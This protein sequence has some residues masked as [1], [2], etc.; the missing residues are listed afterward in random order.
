MWCPPFLVAPPKW[1]WELDNIRSYVR[2][3]I[4]MFCVHGKANSWFVIPG[5][6]WCVSCPSVAATTWP[7]DKQ[8]WQR[9]PRP[10]SVRDSNTW[11]WHRPRTRRMHHW[12]HQ[13][14][15]GQ[16]RQINWL[17][18]FYSS[19]SMHRIKLEKSHTLHFFKSLFLVFGFLINRMRDEFYLRSIINFPISN[20]N[21]Q[22]WRHN[23]TE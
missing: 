22:L 21:S 14:D 10:A 6:V 4:E 17:N 23:A 20:F 8:S 5:L 9:C 1:W 7:R 19:S 11:P 3:I 15:T 13:P 16:T 18:L 12:P 2:F